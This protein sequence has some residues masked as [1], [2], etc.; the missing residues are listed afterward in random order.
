MWNPLWWP[1]AG[2]LGA[3]RHAVCATLRG[4]AGCPAGTGCRRRGQVVSVPSDGQC[5]TGL[6]GP[7]CEPGLGAHSC[8][9][10]GVGP[11]SCGAVPGAGTDRAA[12]GVPWAQQPHERVPCHASDPVSQALRHT[13]WAVEPRPSVCVTGL[14]RKEGGAACGPPTRLCSPLMGQRVITWH[15]GGRGEVQSQGSVEG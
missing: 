7:L 1:D 10:A 8:A 13:P 15:L 11:F 12:C 4:R 5:G 2:A 14:Q 9:P 3:V 6:C